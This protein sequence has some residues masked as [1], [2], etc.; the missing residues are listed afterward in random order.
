[1]P[2]VRPFT[3][4]Q[5]NQWAQ[6]SGFPKVYDEY[7]GGFAPNPAP[8]YTVRG[9]DKTGTYFWLDFVSSSEQASTRW[10]N[11]TGMRLD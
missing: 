8:Q 1:M 9:W 4:Q 7:S 10:N 2:Q 11:D 6:D 5:I 3:K